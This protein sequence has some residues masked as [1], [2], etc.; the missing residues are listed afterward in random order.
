MVNFT[1]RRAWLDVA[2]EVGKNRSDSVALCI[3][4]RRDVMYDVR[5]GKNLTL[6]EVD[7]SKI[8]GRHSF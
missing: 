7:E 2:I 4:W 6:K 5:K 1:N 8:G 3:T